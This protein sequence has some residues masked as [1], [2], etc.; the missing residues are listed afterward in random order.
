MNSEL[1]KEVEAKRGKISQAVLNWGLKNVRYFSWR[2]DRTPY[3]VLVA[4][5]ILRRTTAKAACKIYETFITQYP[6][7][8]ALSNSDVKELERIL[9]AVGY[10]KR[11]ALILKEVAEFTVS[12][13]KAVIP[14]TKD[15]LV[16]VPHIGQYIAGAILSLG[17]GIP[18]AMVDSNVQRIIERLF[19]KKLPSKKRSQSINEIAEAV[20]PKEGHELFNFAM[21]DIGALICR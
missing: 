5:I 13:Y 11:R 7:I 4:E 10:H 16:R 21:L 6:D 3:K 17:Y 18:S 14:N 8:H 19:S 15:D 1:W 2:I 9:S 20:L 12:K